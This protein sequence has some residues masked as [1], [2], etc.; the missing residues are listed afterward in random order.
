MLPLGGGKA[1]N[2]GELI[3]ADLPVPPGVCLTTVAYA[4]EAIE[5]QS[6]VDQL[7]EAEPGQRERLAL[8]IRARLTEVA[9]QEEVRLAIEQA[10]RELGETTLLAVRSSATAEDLPFASFAGQQETILNVSGAAAVLDAVRRCWASLWTERAVVYRA[11][12]GI[13]QRSV[14]LAVVIQQLVDASAAGVLFT[15]DPLT[16]HRYRAVVEAHSGLGEAVVSG[17]VNPD[18]WLVDSVTLRVLDGPGDGCLT[19]HQIRQLVHLGQRVQ[20]LFG[21]PQDIEFAVDA[22]GKVWL[23]QARAITTLYPLPAGAPSDPRQLRVYLSFNVAQGVLRPLTPMGIEAF[24]LIGEGAASIFGVKRQTPLLAEAS[25]R[26]FVDLTTPLRSTFWR[27]VVRF[28]LSQGEARSGLAIDAVLDDPRLAPRPTSRLRVARSVGLALRKSHMPLSLIGAWLW[29]SRAQNAV[30]GLRQ[31]LRDQPL[32]PPSAS[33]EERLAAVE[34]FLHRWPAM[35]VPRIAPVMIGGLGAFA[36]AYRLAGDVGERDDWD[37]VRRA[38]PNN[39]TTEMDLALW[40]LAVASRADPDAR[41]ALS[42][43]SIEQLDEAYAARRLPPALQD[44]LAAFLAE[45]GHR[46]VAEIDV[47]LPRWSEDPTPLLAHLANY[48]ALDERAASP[49]AQ[50]EA[51]AAEAERALHAIVHRT[52]KRSRPRALLVRFLL[53]RGR[54]LAGYREMPKFLAVLILA[55]ARGV[56]LT[57]GEDLLERGVMERADDVF[58]LTFDDARRSLR[59]PDARALVAQR[60]ARYAEELR[61]RHVP[62]L[63]LSDGTEPQPAGD[64]A[65]IA[66]ADGRVLRGTPASAGRV[67]G[68]ARVI[69][70]PAGARLAPGE[71]LV[72]PSTDPGWT[73]LFLTAG[74]LVM[75]MGGAMSH[76]AVVAREYGIP[77]VVGV[78]AATERIADGEAIRV[79]GSS[80]TVQ[81]LVIND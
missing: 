34:D 30:A 26:L 23:V 72:A 7:S 52:A 42:E 63:L 71:I 29:P 17:A 13:D 33:P 37:A 1:V 57:V 41:A 59:G 22:T 78:P 76:G 3:R 14:H 2:L 43:R 79:D 47:G 58:F 55:R 5:V 70:E 9:I 19:S 48:L 24:R 27:R 51:A 62:R 28:A 66:S 80:G 56:L 12:N 15:A 45:Y 10:V 16:G 18:H 31:S 69:I 38:L 68:R 8:Q 60:R 67:E 74:G 21:A 25:G 46:A 75:E 11:N 81:R 20:G 65:M 77:A 64:A 6:L 32:P 39:P 73:P 49:A 35:T 36:L 53:R 40:E 50:F 44:G 61:R 54:A 4:R